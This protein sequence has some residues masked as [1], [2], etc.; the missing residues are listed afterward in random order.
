[1]SL[2]EGLIALNVLQLFFWTWQVHKLVNKLMCRDLAEYRHI[3]RRPVKVEKSNS[4]T[5]HDELLEEA[6][7]LNEI[8]AVFKGAG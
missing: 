8:N 3:E 2:V 7:I 5:A 1:M 4:N 6:E